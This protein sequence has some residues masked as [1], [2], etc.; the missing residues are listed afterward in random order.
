MADGRDKLLRRQVAA[1]VKA[2]RISLK[3]SQEA[4]ALDAGFHRTFIGH[5]ERAETNVSVDSLERLALAL[6]IPAYRLLLVSEASVPE[7]EE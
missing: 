1:N 3:L 4:V 6:R 5:I 7:D 2:R